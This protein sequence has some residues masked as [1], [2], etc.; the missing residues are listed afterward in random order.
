MQHARLWPPLLFLALLAACDERATPVDG[1]T[2]PGPDAGEAPDARTDAGGHADEDAGSCDVPCG[3]ACCRETQ[4]CAHAT[5]VPDLG[6]CAADDDCAGDSYCD[7]GRCT[8]YGVPPDVTHDPTCERPIEIGEF[9]PDEQCHWV[10]PPSGEPYEDWHEVYS[11][12]VVAD[13]DLDDDPSVLR[14]SIV[15]AT[16]KDDTTRESQGGILRILDGRTCDAHQSLPDEADRVA[17]ATTVAVGDLDGAPDGRPEIVAVGQLVGSRASGIVAF[18]YD[19]SRGRIARRFY[20][21]RCDLV[22]E[23]RFT[24]TG[25]SS[26]GGPSLHDLDD[27]GRPEIVAA[28]Y[29]YDHEGCVLN[30]DRGD[31]GRHIFPVIA[32]VD[33]DGLP[34][35]VGHGGVYAWETAERRWVLEPYWTSGDEPSRREGFVAVADFGDFPGAAGDAPGRAEI[36]VVSPPFVGAPR[37]TTEPGV[38]RVLST[39]GDVVFGPAPLPAEGSRPAGRGGAPT[40]ADFDGDGR[41]EIGVAGGSR[42]TVFD[43]DC[44][45]G[46]GPGCDRAA[47]QPDGVLWSRPSHDFS[48]NTTGASVFDFD[49]DGVAEVVYRDECFLR[50]YRG[51]D[52][53]VLFSRAASSLT[54]AEYP[55]VADVDGDFNSEIVVPLTYLATATTEACPATDPIFEGGTVTY[56]RS[57]GVLVLRDERDRWAASRPIWN[58]HA[59]AVTHVSEAGAVPRTSEWTPNHAT[60]DL[61]TFRANAQGALERTGVADLTVA[62]ARPAELC[63]AATGEV[64]LEARVCNRG[65]NPATDGARVV[66]HLGDPDAGAPVACETRLPRWVG[67]GECATVSCAYEL[68]GEPTLRDVTVVVDPDAETFECRRGNNR[69]VIAAVYCDLL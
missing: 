48:S 52:G 63:D 3:G 62:L 60:A 53:E 19:A 67:V 22:D 42:L 46:A 47:G 37:T 59:Y 64:E 1:G 69:G 56:E 2:D 35:L 61:N 58:Q 9:A 68:S 50:I 36:V 18:G 45:D 5:C 41:P 66:F 8:P 17:Y 10:A 49:A 25:I 16:W 27:D 30:P 55:V 51:T 44:A 28:G 11:T 40:V 7:G 54:G 13:F 6:P 57:S 38:V 32:D 65:T 12:P 43:L 24:P 31:V 39:G 34:E 21:R 23:P 33:A 26:S 20:G 15:V 4:R 29:V 14:P